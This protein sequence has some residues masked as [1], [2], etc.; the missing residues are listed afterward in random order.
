[1]MKAPL[2]AEPTVRITINRHWISVLSLFSLSLFL[3]LVCHTHTH[4]SIHPRHG[5]TN[6]NSWQSVTA[7][8]LQLR[9]VD[10]RQL[11][12]GHLEKH[13][14]SMCRLHDRDTWRCMSRVCGGCKIDWC[15]AS[16]SPQVCCIATAGA[17]TAGTAT[18]TEAVTILECNTSRKWICLSC[19]DDWSLT[20]NQAYSKR[21]WSWH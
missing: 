6:H 8:T 9:R 1:M 7:A 20:L 13:I 3:S 12:Q 4:L 21:Y 15:N 16:K 11:L 5:F 2:S 10:A 19:K 14:Q 17:L 18:C